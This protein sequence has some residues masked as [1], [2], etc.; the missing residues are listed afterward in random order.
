MQTE[1]STAGLVEPKESEIRTQLANILDDAEFKRSPKISR[2]LE[3]VVE[4]ALAGNQQYLKAHSIAIAV[5]DKDETFDPQVDPV[6]RV[7]AVRLR[8]ML[9]QYYSTRDV[10]EDVMIDIIK[11][12]YVPHFYYTKKSDEITEHPPTAP[13]GCAFPS[14]AV[15]DFKNLSSNLAYGYIADGITQEVVN[16]LCKFKEIMVVARSLTNYNEDQLLNTKRLLEII[17]VRYVLSGSVRIE[18]KIIRIN[19]ELDDTTTHTI[20]WTHEYTNKLNVDNIISIEDEIA[21]HV[22]VNVAQPYGVIIRK[23]LANLDRISTKDLNA[24]QLYLLFYQWCLTLSPNDHLKA[25]DALEKVVKIDPTFSDAWAALAMIYNTE[26]QLSCNQI[27]R[28]KDVRD[29]AFETAQKAI[30]TDPDNAR[31][32]YAIVF[33]NMTKYGTRACLDQAEKV[34]R[35]YPYHSLYIAVYG[36]RLAVCG[37][38]AHGLR[39]IKHAMVINPSHPDFYHLPFVLDYYRRDMYTEA[40][41]EARKINMPD[42]FWANLIFAALYAEVGEKDQMQNSIEKLIEIYPDINQKAR[43]ELEKWDTQTELKEKL[44]NGL[45]KAGLNIT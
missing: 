45:Q 43:F 14:I 29:I 3:Y 12:S 26:Y 17:D 39:L 4:E 8:R 44:I 34:Y 15:L 7:N 19:V 22:A 33:S 38:W 13:N 10:K 16:Q 40:I 18:D 37:E 32:H 5:F 30:K 25:R 6:V 21:I 42:Y 28:D 35:L 23:E 9:R 11:G 41:I 20:I 1:V 36:K 31:A 24:Y 27:K 2:F